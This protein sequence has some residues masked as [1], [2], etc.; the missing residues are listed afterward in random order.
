MSKAL[1]LELNMG[2]KWDPNRIFDAEALGKSL[3]ALLDGFGAEKKVL[4][5]ALGRPEGTSET[6]FS[7]PGG[8]IP[9][10]KSPGGSQME[11]RK[12]SKLKVAKP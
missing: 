4:G 6:G 9:P 3:G 12:R 2:P 10:K 11:V 1:F 7:M 5:S 8:K